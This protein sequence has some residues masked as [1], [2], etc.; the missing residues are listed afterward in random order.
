ME[1]KD[2]KFLTKYR[3]G[4][5]RILE[6][7]YEQTRLQV[8][9]VYPECLLGGYILDYGTGEGFI[10]PFYKAITMAW[11]TPELPVLVFSETT[12]SVGYH[13]ANDSPGRP[14]IRPTGSYVKG[15]RSTIGM[16]DHPGYIKG[17][18]KLWKRWGAHAEFVG[19]LWLDRIPEENLAENLYHIGKT[20]R[21]Y[22]LY[23]ML[24]LGDN[25]RRMLPGG[26]APAYW[27]A[28]AQA[29]QELD[30]LRESK[31]T[32]VSELKVRRFTLPAPSV[33]LELWKKVDLP[34]TGYPFETNKEF[35]WN[36]E[37]LF[38]IPVQAGDKVQLTVIADSAHATKVKT[39]AMAIILVDPAGKVIKR[40]KMTAEDLIAGTEQP[41]GRYIAR[42]P[43]R[44]QATKTG[45]YGLYLKAMRFS[46]TLGD[47]SHPVY[48]AR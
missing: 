15:K 22:W 47:C 37:V 24:S 36:K 43:V 1:L 27:Q 41:N 20:T 44:F 12:Y 25:P 6:R 26:G 45:V 5:T 16:G 31:G 2:E 34:L 18:L 32:Y 17:W 19:G 33:S 23:E 46:Y 38:Y 28:I 40:D 14:L 7:I 39:D 4:S 21:G 30:K 29:N 48:L 13:T 3:E 8:H 35:F 11:G 10:P 42:R 9:A